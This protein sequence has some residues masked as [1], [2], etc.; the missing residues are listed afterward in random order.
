MFGRRKKQ[1]VNPFSD[2]D[3][4]LAKL[5]GRLDEVMHTE[6]VGAKLFKLGKLKSEIDA[7]LCNMQ[8]DIERH[9][10]EKGALAF[11]GGLFGSAATMAGIT[12]VTGIPIFILAFPSLI[13]TEIAAAKY[14][15]ITKSRLEK[16]SLDLIN[17]LKSQK[18]LV[19]AAVDKVL[20]E[21]L[22]GVARSPNRERLFEAY[23]DIR[24]RFAEAA[25]RKMTAPEKTLSQPADNDRPKP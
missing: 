3:L 25:A 24:I 18:Q 17:T 19:S 5:Q 7:V 21:Q 11:I 15:K 16:E 20:D 6:D 1:A 14:Q 2:Q 9:A 13:G 12:V 10:G 8:A 23:P 22:E 4:L